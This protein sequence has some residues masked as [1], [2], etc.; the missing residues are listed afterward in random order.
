MLRILLLLLLLTTPSLAQNTTN[1]ALVG[2]SGAYNA[3][4]KT[5][6]DGQ[7][8]LLQTDSNG[9]LKTVASG[10]PSGTQNIS[11]TVTY[12]D[13]SITSATGSSQTLAAANLTRKSLVIVNPVEG[14]T[15]WG[16][17]TQGA[18]VIGT[19]PTIKL[20]PGDSWSPWPVP[21]NAVTGIGTSTSQLV[22]LEGN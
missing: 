13:K 15:A 5:C 2:D 17:S 20:N 21:T 16:I 18:A 19:A 4:P 1:P 3:S 8:C 7:F 9:N 10:T 11:A 6:T 22:V 12:T 14:T